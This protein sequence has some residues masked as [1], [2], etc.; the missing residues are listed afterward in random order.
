MSNLNPV[1]FYRESFRSGL[2][3]QLNDLHSYCGKWSVFINRTVVSATVTVYDYTTD[4]IHT[5]SMGWEIT[6]KETLK[7]CSAITVTNPTLWNIVEGL[8]DVEGIKVEGF[9]G[10]E[11]FGFED[12]P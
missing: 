8:L 2:Y 11:V 9:Q 5:V 7:R 10:R 12:D 1:I 4:K 3:Y 6:G